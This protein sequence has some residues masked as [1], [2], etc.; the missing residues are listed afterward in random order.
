MGTTD[1]YSA[2]DLQ[3]EPELL[4]DGH[5]CRWDRQ[6]RVAVGGPKDI[7]QSDHVGGTS[8]EGGGNGGTFFMTCEEGRAAAL[9]G[10]KHS[11]YSWTCVAS[12]N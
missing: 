10:L 4:S 8:A 12:F 11:H 3:I 2:F 5:V 9:I 7:P 6:Q 1:F